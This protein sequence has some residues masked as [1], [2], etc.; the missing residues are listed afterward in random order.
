MTYDHAISFCYPLG[1]AEQGTHDGVWG[2]DAIAVS[3]DGTIPRDVGLQTLENTA[4]SWGVIRKSACVLTEITIR[5]SQ[6][7]GGVQI[8]VSQPLLQ[9]KCRDSLLGLI[10][11]ER[12]PEGMTGCLLGNPCLFAILHNKF[13]NPPL[14]DRLA[15]I[16]EKDSR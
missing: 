3:C 1:A 6:D 13:A 14:G 9:L 11:R 4:L 10:R 7:L 5:K 8:R 15:L 12:M 16:I 2:T